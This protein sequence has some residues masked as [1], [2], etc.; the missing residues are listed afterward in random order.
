MYALEPLC[1]QTHIDTLTQT[2]SH[3]K[4]YTKPHKYSLKKHKC[5]QETPICS[6]YSAH[7]QSPYTQSSIAYTHDVTPKMYTHA[8]TCTPVHTCLPDRYTCTKNTS[9]HAQIHKPSFNSGVCLVLWSE[10]QSFSTDT[11]SDW[12]LSVLNFFF[13]YPSLILLFPSCLSF[14]TSPSSPSVC[15]SACLAHSLSVFFSPVFCPALA[16]LSTTL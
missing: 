2:W 5:S 16:W 4:V 3:T 11:E 12:R 7:T 6:K 1:L 9:K 13:F 8:Q 15:A 10:F 14:H